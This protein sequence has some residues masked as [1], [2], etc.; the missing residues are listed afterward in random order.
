MARENSG[1]H[2]L[3]LYKRREAQGA[4]AGPT[5]F[6]KLRPQQ[7]WPPLYCGCE[8]LLGTKAWQGGKKGGSS[9]PFSGGGVGGYP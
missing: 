9:T 2:P 7:Q 6:R 3:E 5:H 1:A 4:G 8:S